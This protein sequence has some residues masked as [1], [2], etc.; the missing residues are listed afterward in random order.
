MMGAHG[1]LA[2][3]ISNFLVHTDMCVCVCVVCAWCVVCVF[4]V[5]VCVCVCGVCVCG[6]C[7]C[8]R[9]CGVCVCVCLRV[10][11]C[12]CYL[13]TYICA[14]AQWTVC[15]RLWVMFNYVCR[16]KLSQLFIFGSHSSQTTGVTVCCRGNTDWKCWTVKYV[17]C[18]TYCLASCF[19]INWPGAPGL[20]FSVITWCFAWIGWNP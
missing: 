6:V 10:C 8:M 16:W 18:I 20:Y 7:V 5:C 1:P 12:V 4:V 15:I 3:R 13:C 14:W 2:A 19:L 11:M 17:Y 9:V